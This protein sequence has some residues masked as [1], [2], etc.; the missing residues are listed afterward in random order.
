MT[1]PVLL[2]HPANLLDAV[3]YSLAFSLAGAAAAVELIRGKY[4]RQ[5]KYLVQLHVYYC[6]W[7]ASSL[8]CGEC[9]FILRMANDRIPLVYI[10]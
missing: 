2:R 7:E 3:W 5:M 1:H 8:N 10:G 6:S 9:A 4:M